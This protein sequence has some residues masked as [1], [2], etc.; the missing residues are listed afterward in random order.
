[1]AAYGAPAIALSVLALPLY[2]IVPTFYADQLGLSLASI[3]AVLLA[4][5]LLDAFCDPFFGWMSDRF[6]SVLGRRRGFFLLSLPLSAFATFMLFWPPVN[7]GIV[8]LGLWAGLASIGYTWTILPYTAWGA[9]LATDYSDRLRVTGW[10]E[11]A[12]LVGTL[13]AIAAPFSI[14]LDSAIGFHGLAAVGLFVLIALPVAGIIAIRMVP[15]PENPSVRLLGPVEGIVYFARNRPFLRLIAAFLLNGFANAIPATLFLYFVS[16][17][18]GEP[19]LRGPLLFLYFLAA[20]AGVPIAV[21][22]AHRFG[23]HRTWC[24]AMAL[25][26]VIFFFAGFLGNGD[27]LAFAIICGLTG[28]LLGF[29]LALP[30]AIQ[31]DVIDLDTVNS[32]EQRS[33][34]YFAAWSLA[35]KVALALGVGVVFPILAWAGFNASA[36]PVFALDTLSVLYAWLPI[37]PKTAAILLM[38]NFPLGAIQQAELRQQIEVR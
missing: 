35:T 12:G 3:G 34:I 7:A 17:R 27:A 5:R 14:G 29:D 31:A 23:K 30:P 25:A 1:M 13:I 26:C 38:W 36:S 18:L 32:G 6:L 4:I 19:E 15:E 28:L 16:D 33:G 20:I 8:Y 10:R 2:I 21:T 9:E 11:G 37:I 22:M 24:A